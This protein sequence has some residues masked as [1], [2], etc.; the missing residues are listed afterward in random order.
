MINVSSVV[1]Y[2]RPNSNDQITSGTL[3]FDDGSIYNVGALPNGGA[4]FVIPIKNVATKT[5][6]F[7]VTG[8]SPSTGNAGLT[9]FAVYGSTM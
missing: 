7:N 5:I 3:R 8:V 6:T 4:A 1:L 2:D 9:E